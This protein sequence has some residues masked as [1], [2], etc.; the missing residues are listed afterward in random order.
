[1]TADTFVRE[2]HDRATRGMSLTSEEQ[3]SLIDWYARQDRAENA[4]LREQV[5]QPI[6]ALRIQLDAA[7][8]E[9]RAAAERIQTL[10]ADNEARRREIDGLQAQLAERI[11]ATRA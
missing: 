8:A 11:S 5:P 10:T 2:L 1:M 3:Q 9:L 4:L 7:V 6:T